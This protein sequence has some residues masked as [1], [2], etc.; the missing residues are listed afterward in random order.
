MKSVRGWKRL[1]KNR[2]LILYT[3]PKCIAS[4]RDS[5]VAQCGNASSCFF[6]PNVGLARGSVIGRAGEMGIAGSTDTVCY[7]R[8]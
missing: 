2:S 5:G 6:Y 4:P 8:W 1:K 7:N 3:R